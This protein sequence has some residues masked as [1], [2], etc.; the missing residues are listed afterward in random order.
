MSWF[1]F[2]GDLAKS[3]GDAAGP[4]PLIAAVPNPALTPVPA[5]N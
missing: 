2:I 4:D 5:Q 3:C 1:T